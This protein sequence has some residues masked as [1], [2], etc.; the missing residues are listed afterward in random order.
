MKTKSVFK[1]GMLVHRYLQGAG[2]T[3]GGDELDVVSR[4][5]KA[6]VFLD[7]V[8]GFRSWIEKTK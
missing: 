3:T 5:V 2:F 4:V 7:N 6:G 8:P 1:K